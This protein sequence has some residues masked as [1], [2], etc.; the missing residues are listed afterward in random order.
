M[1]DASG[2]SIRCR[3]VAVG[4]EES[5]LKACYNAGEL[6]NAAQVLYQ[7]WYIISQL[8]YAVRF[9]MQATAPLT[10]FM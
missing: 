9:I 3:H 4:T 8:Q 6:N 2:I 1:V 5:R 10:L 7:K